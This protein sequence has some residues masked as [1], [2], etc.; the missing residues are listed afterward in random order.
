M[1]PK[2]DQNGTTNHKKNGF[3]R[4]LGVLEE[5]VFSMFL[6]RK[7]N[8]PKIRKNLEKTGDAQTGKIARPGGMRGASGEVR[9]G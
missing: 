3:L 6:E 4:F 8:R 9:R 7:G 2:S 5:T 1:D